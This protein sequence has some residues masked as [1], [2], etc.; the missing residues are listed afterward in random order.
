MIQRD[1]MYSTVQLVE[2]TKGRS[3]LVSNQSPKK[4]IESFLYY[5]C[6][7]ILA[8]EAGESV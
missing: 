8:T 3:H 5:T 6:T 4:I 2:V 7:S 1:N